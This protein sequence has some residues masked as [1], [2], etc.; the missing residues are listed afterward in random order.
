MLIV[1]A[2][3]FGSSELATNNILTCY[4]NNRITSVSAMMFMADSERSADLALE[5]N[6]TVGLHLN[7]T[8]K[9]DG[10]AGPERLSEYQQRI[11][12]FLSKGKFP[13]LLYNPFLKAQFDYVYKAQY[14]EFTRLYNKEPIH[15]DGHCH[16]HL[17]MNMI[18]DKIIPEGFKIRRNFT[19]T[20]FE[21]NPLNI[22]YRYLVDKWLVH[23]YICTDF[24]FSISPVTQLLRLREIIN[25]A[26]LSNVEL[27]VHPEKSEEYTFLL[28]E[29]FLQ[30][31][32]GISMGTYAAL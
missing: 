6:L 21:K 2:D 20:C 22:L 24:F 29:E 28:C 30:L 8:H 1:N 18:I 3:D 11:A 7:F 32:S 27:M 12:L 16:M 14:D 17:C 23:R 9:F 26:K 5:Y 31:T 10:C 15:I 25:L 4:K 13:F 19:F